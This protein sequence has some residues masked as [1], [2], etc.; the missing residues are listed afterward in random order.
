M[1]QELENKLG[2]LFALDTNDTLDQLLALIELPDE[3]FDAFY[4]TIQ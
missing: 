3:Q 2:E 4:P 1:K